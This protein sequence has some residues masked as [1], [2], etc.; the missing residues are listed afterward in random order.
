MTSTSDPKGLFF[1]VFP[2]VKHVCAQKFGFSQTPK[3]KREKPGMLVAIISH[4]PAL[5]LIFFCCFAIFSY[6]SKNTCI[7]SFYRNTTQNYLFD[8]KLKLD[9]TGYISKRRPHLRY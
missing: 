5:N 2:L 3:R 9:N 1:L 7:E 4:K 8:V 6:M